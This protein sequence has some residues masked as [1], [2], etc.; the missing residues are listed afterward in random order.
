MYPVYCSLFLKFTKCYYAIS[1]FTS[2]TSPSYH[3]QA[4]ICHEKY[5]SST[6][7]KPRLLNCISL[8]TILHRFSKQLW[9][10]SSLTDKCSKSCFWSLYI[11]YPDDQRKWMCIRTQICTYLWTSIGCALVDDNFVDLAKLPKVLMFLQNLTK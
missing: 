8:I 6:K 9:G 11:I 5:S 4:H 3:L 2:K 10:M 1:L 7:Q